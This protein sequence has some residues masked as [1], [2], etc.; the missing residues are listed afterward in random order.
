MPNNDTLAWAV[1]KVIGD[2]DSTMD[3]D[4]DHILGWTRMGVLMLCMG[5]A[6][7]FDHKERRVSNEHWIVWSKPIVFIWSLD[8]LIQQ[9]HWSV[10]LTASALLAYAS[11]SVIGRPTVRDARKGNR[12]D[13]FVFVWYF[14]STIGIIAAAIRFSSTS[15]LDVLVGD[16]SSEATLW[17]SYI[18]ALFTLFVIDLAWRFRFIHGGADAKA[19][20]WVT[21]LFPSWDSVPVHFT[22]SMDEVILHLPP[23][24]SLLIWGGFLFI[25]I[26]LVLIVRNTI[27]G[28][29]KSFSDLIMS[30]M[31]L[32]IPLN[33]VHGRHVW[34][35]TDTMEMPNGETI[36]NNK[37]R[38]PRRT[39]TDEEMK[40][41]IERLEAFG[42][43]RIWVSLKL[44]L[45][46]FLFPAI[47]PL[48]LIGDPMAALL[49]LILP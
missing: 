7:W 19:L 22:T 11:G 36:L 4:S 25:L 16:A 15:P 26:P 49:P 5:W 28:S 38:A 40:E 34:I 31:A 32:S 41:H 14:L 21:L 8:L 46:L 42:T 3:V 35:L 47:A 48:W 13:Q 23:S 12:V 24:L 30:W 37:K 20:M 27:S 2:M 43:E 44:P 17:W 6:A 10:W 1:F 33:T 45:L 29:V 18:G 39:P 9:P